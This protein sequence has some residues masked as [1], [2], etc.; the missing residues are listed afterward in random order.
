MIESGLRDLNSIESI[1]YKNIDVFL[2]E[3][4]KFEL[5]YK[6]RASKNKQTIFPYYNLTFD[7]AEPFSENN[8]TFKA[9]HF[10][11]KIQRREK[12]GSASIRNLNIILNCRKRVSL[13]LRNLEHLKKNLLVNRIN[14]VRLFN[15]I[16]INDLSLAFK[17][18][19]TIFNKT[20]MD[21]TILISGYSLQSKQDVLYSNQLNKKKMALPSSIA[22]NHYKEVIKFLLNYLTNRNLRYNLGNIFDLDKLVSSSVNILSNM[23]AT[24]FKNPDNKNFFFRDRLIKVA[25]SKIITSAC[26]FLVV[27]VAISFSVFFVFKHF[28][29]KRTSSSNKRLSKDIDPVFT[30]QPENFFEKEFETTI[31]KRSN[32]SLKLNMRSVTASSSSSSSSLKHPNKLSLRILSSLE[33]ARKD[34]KKKKLSKTGDDNEF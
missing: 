1:T 9:T 31:A 24:L 6:L 27:I 18:R 25:K 2:G 28:L 32:S 13:S 3:G 12:L 5:I 26:V 19:Y 21:K 8:K 14:S 11:F 10:H 17:E 23:N 22:A 15:C 16:F 29:D 7:L 20:S 33:K 4:I 30:V 34:L